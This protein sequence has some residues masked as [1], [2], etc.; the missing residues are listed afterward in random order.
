MSNLVLVAQNVI[1]ASWGVMKEERMD[2]ELCY[3]LFSAE[4]ESTHHWLALNRNF[5]PLIWQT[6][7]L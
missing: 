6:I 3:P 5:R 2:F 7:K 4:L 1:Q